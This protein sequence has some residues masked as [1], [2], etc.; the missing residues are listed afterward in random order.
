MMR[1]CQGTPAVLNGSAGGHDKELALH[2][3]QF[4]QFSVFEKGSEFRI[5]QHAD[6]KDGNEGGDHVFPTETFIERGFVSIH[7]E[8]P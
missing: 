2:G 3:V 7:A 5:G 1:V 6:I 8:K 4:L